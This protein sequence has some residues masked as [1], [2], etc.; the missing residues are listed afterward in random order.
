M[1]SVAELAEAVR[2]APGPF[3]VRGGGSK[4]DGGSKA[5][6]KWLRPCSP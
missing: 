1:R 5:H 3:V 2:S 6:G 4:Q